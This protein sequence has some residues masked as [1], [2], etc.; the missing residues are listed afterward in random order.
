MLS[1]SGDARCHGITKGGRRCTI[2]ARSTMKDAAGRFVGLPLALGAPCCLYHAVLFTTYPAELPDAVVVFLDLETDSLDPLSGNFVEIGALVGGS[3]AAFST[4]V[5][6]GCRGTREA[7][8]VHV[9]SPEELEQSPCFV[10]A[11]QRLDQFLRFASVSVLASD[12]D[13]DDE[14]APPTAM[15]PDL[16]IALVAHNALR[17]DYP[18]LPAECLRA[19]LGASTMSHWFFVDTMELLRSTNFAGECK[20]LQCSFRVCSGPSRLQAHRA[21]DDCIALEAVV[22][23]VSARMG[24]TPL[25]LLRCFARRMDEPATIA[26][27]GAL[28]VD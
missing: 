4:V 3:R 18:F 6:P 24:V 8:A 22:E 5:N 20:K 12:S 25:N 26:Q 19:G 10:E 17:F 13:S 27:L 23:F 9:I 7:D 2:T 14:A 1:P 16:A 15:K 28:L 21:L 11:F